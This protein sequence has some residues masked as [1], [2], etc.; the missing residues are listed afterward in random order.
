MRLMGQATLDQGLLLIQ[1]L[2]NTQQLIQKSKDT[3]KPKYLCN[4]M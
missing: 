1:K 3:L 4:L 2:H